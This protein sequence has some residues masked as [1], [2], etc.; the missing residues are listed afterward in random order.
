MLIK[1]GKFYIVPWLILGI[2]KNANE[3]CLSGAE[4]SFDMQTHFDMLIFINTITF[5]FGKDFELQLQFHPA[6]LCTEV[7]TSAAHVL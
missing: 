7:V 4:L 5:L 6:P 3:H 2:C 1:L